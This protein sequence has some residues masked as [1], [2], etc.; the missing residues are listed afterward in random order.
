MRAASSPR[1][2]PPATT[3]RSFPRDIRDERRTNDHSQQEQLAQ[4]RHDTAAA[5]GR[6]H[7]AALR[8]RPTVVDC[9]CGQAEHQHADRCWSSRSW[10]P[11][12]SARTGSPGQQLERGVAAT[13]SPAQPPA[14]GGV[15]AQARAALRAAA[16]AAA[17]AARPLTGAATVEGGVQK[18]SVDL[19]PGSYNPNIIQL[20]AG[21][22][23]EI[24]F[25]QSRR[26]HRHR[27]VPG[28]RLPGGPLRPVP[29]P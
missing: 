9:G 27:P 14:A 8:T 6:R 24:T 23:A 17:A 13:A 4:G 28:P 16:V 3:P 29:R 15:S 25:S 20:K 1:S 18:I 26:L 21:V 7:P 10:S 22:P 2:V 12:S 5:Q 19:S 11:P